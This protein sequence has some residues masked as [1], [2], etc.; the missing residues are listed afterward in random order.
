[1]KNTS[2]DDR[3]VEEI[4]DALDAGDARTALAR[5]RIALHEMGEDPVLHFLAGTA[6][7]DLDEPAAA[8][9]D[10]ERAVALD[11]DDA[12]FRAAL[13]YALYK[14]CRFGDAAAAAQKALEADPGLPD[15]LHAAALI[16]ERE[17]RVE[18]ADRKFARASKLDPERFPPPVR[19][20][21]EEFEKE[22]V[23]AGEILPAEFRK[24]LAGIAVTVED[25]PSIAILVEE[26]PPLDPELL[27]LFVGSALDE[28][29]FQGPVAAH[30]ARILLF[31]RNLERQV[32]DEGLLRDEIART[33]HHELAHY[34]GFE[35]DDM[36]GLDL[37]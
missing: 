36:P 17:G 6:L 13:A 24:H 31:K 4:Y 26:S 11:P 9:E 22:V 37:D 23:A 5:A 14:A 28:M 27:G 16:D 29:T 20:S 33:L 21:R 25:L 15:A 8:A 19:I 12:E 18:E 32:D 30:P 1:M 35:E 3:I 7:L 2:D 34:L 10:L